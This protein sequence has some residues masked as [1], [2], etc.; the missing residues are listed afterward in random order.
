[1][2]IPAPPTQ[3]VVERLYQFALPAA[4]GAALVVCLFAL[5]GRWAGALGS[6][7]AVVVAFL[8]ANFAP[9]A[10]SWDSGDKPFPWVETGRPIPWKPDAERPQAWHW[11][12]RAALTLVVV[13][14][15]TRWLGLFAA[16][17]MPERRWWVVN[18]LVW[19]P[20]IGAAAAVAGWLVADKWSAEYGAWLPYALAAVIVAEWAVLDGIARA[21]AGGQVALYL[22][23]IFLATSALML[24]HHWSTPAEVAII[25]GCAFFG[26]AVA[27]GATRSDASGAVPG[28]V[29]FLPPLVL[30]GRMQ[31][32][33]PVPLAA[34]WLVA[35]APLAL[36]PFLIPRLNRQ[37]GWVARIARLVLILAPVTVALVLAARHSTLAF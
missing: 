25:L 29:G 31:Q 5:L 18:L 24:F 36:L 27:A 20:R 6:A 9:P 7:A 16:R 10:G 1:M 28:G 8:W 37:N 34:F 19:L 26:V 17:Y 32:D 35:L 22:T 12:P 23:V 3:D 15:F 33:S 30:A 2:T 11:L 14:L 21:G 4:G 13:G